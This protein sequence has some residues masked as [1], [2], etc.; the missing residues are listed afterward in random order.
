VRVPQGV[1]AKE[2][3]L[4]WVSQFGSPRAVYEGC[5]PG[6][7]RDC[8][9]PKGVSQGGPPS[10]SPK[11][12]SLKGSPLMGVA[13]K[14][15]RRGVPPV[16]PAGC[17][18]GSLEWSRMGESHRVV[19]QGVHQGFPQGSPEGV[20][21]GLPQWGPPGGSPGIFKGVTHRLPQGCQ[22]GCSH[23]EVP[24]ECPPRGFPRGAPSVADPNWVS[25]LGLPQCASTNL[26][27]LV[28][29]DDVSARGVH[30]G[31]PPGW[32]TWGHPRS[33]PKGNP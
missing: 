16:G 26:W 9:T 14:V 15:S 30:Q 25:P 32:T 18:R 13:P 3:P 31:C 12:G 22:P 21:D 11:G 5:H 33:P 23:K 10:G 4:G 6:V 27:P 24:E 29:P 1:S 2:C 28:V 7:I 17:S 19:S 8:G 20:P